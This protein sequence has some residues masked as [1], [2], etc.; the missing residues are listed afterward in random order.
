[1]NTHPHTELHTHICTDNEHKHI[2]DFN[3]AHNVQ[4]MPLSTKELLTSLVKRGLR[5]ISYSVEM[6]LM[7]TNTDS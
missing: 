3:R 6:V 7:E 4:G 2:H 1:M 5:I